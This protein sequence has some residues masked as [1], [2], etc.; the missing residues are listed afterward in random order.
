MTHGSA[1]TSERAGAPPSERSHTQ[2]GLSTRP[3]LTRARALSLFF[4]LSHPSVSCKHDDW[5][6]IEYTAPYHAAAARYMKSLSPPLAPGAGPTRA[7]EAVGVDA[8]QVWVFGAWTL[9]RCGCV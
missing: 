2:P 7:L 6:R 8:R 3:P 9:G 1:S 4:S 5:N